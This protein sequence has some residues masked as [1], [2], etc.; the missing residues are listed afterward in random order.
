MAPPGPQF[1]YQAAAATHE[2]RLAKT[3]IA[4]GV[5]LALA[6]MLT[7]G[8]VV[9]WLFHRRS[10]RNENV[11]ATNDHGG[12]V[13]VKVDP[14]GAG[15][16]GNARGMSY[17]AVLNNQEIVMGGGSGLT[18]AQLSG[19]LRNASFVPACGAPDDMKVMVRVALKMG[20]P[21][22]VT[23]TTSPP[24]GAVAACI[25]R[26]VRG[27]RWPANAKTD[28]VTTS[29]WAWPHPV[30]AIGNAAFYAATAAAWTPFVA[31]AWHG[32]DRGE[33]LVSRDGV[34]WAF[35]RRDEDGEWVGND[36]AGWVDQALVNRIM[37]EA[38]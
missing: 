9:V 27:L 36:L 10:T 15:G 33:W 30:C 6:G 25:E 22:G 3:I 4:V 20:A 1:S 14:A 2:N 37:R 34:H 18:N 5:V 12:P 8:L 31:S 29:Y 19:P 23:V 13:D 32:P 16:N 24:N 26:S 21:I 17:E 38:R 28:F 7:V 11:A 35:V